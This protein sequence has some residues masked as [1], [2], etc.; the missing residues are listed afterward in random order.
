M[1]GQGLDATAYSRGTSNAAAVTSRAAA[2][3]YDVIVSLRAQVVDAPGEKFDAVLLKALLVHGAHWRD[4]PHRLLAERPEFQLIQ[5]GN[6]RRAAELD[7]V[8]R[9]LGYGVA[10]VERALTC[11]AERATLLGVGELGADE[12]LVL[13]RTAAAG[14]G[15]QDRMASADAHARMAVADQRSAPRLSPSQAVGR[16]AP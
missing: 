10:D 3:A 13:L 6:S 16:S 9:W 5:N 7:F 1:P 14:S 12:A 8:T 15:R 11:T 4:G 2:K